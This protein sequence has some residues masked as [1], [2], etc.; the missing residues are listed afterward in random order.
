[1]RR[2]VLLLAAS[3][4]SHPEQV[5]GVVLDTRLVSLRS[6]LAGSARPV[7]P[8]KRV[9]KPRAPVGAVVISNALNLGWLRLGCLLLGLSSASRKSSAPYIGMHLLTHYLHLH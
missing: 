2:A 8:V 1:M 6:P 5:L 9:G 4:L 7:L 3:V